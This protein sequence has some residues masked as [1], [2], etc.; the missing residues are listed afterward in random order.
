MT[1]MAASDLLR[2]IG[3]VANKK[4]VQ[5]DTSPLI[6]QDLTVTDAFTFAA[7]VSNSIDLV[8]SNCKFIGPVLFPN[9]SNLQR[10]AFE[11]CLFE[12]TIELRDFRQQIV[13][14]GSVFNKEVRIHSA[15]MKDFGI[16]NILINDKLALSGS[17]FGIL[18]LSNINSG[19]DRSGIK[20]G[21]SSTRIK[22]LRTE[23]IVV[24]RFEVKETQLISDAVF[25]NV[26]ADF[27]DFNIVQIGHILEILNCDLKE[28]RLDNLTANHERHVKIRD[29]KIQEYHV[30]LNMYNRLEVTNTTFRRLTLSGI[31]SGYHKIEKTDAQTLRLINVINEGT[32]ILSQ[33]EVPNGGSLE[34]KSSTLGKTDFLLCKFSEAR[35]EFENSKVS[36]IFCSETDFPKLVTVNKK[37]NFAQAQLAFGQLNTAFSKQGDTV[38][39]LEYQSREIE[40]HYNNINWSRK[41]F[42]TKL[43]LGL[44]MLSSN[45]G[46]WWGRAVL[47][48]FTVGALFFYLVVLW[49]E[50]YSFALPIDFDSRLIPS[51]L[52]FMNPLRVFDTEALFRV[53]EPSS[54]LTLTELSYVFDF[55]GR[56]FVAY[57]F[58]QTIQAFRRFGRK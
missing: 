41:N 48:T 8:F 51:Y 58:Y 24:N 16:A 22:H 27:L 19:N 4:E 29:C 55:I 31:N 2:E 9:S 14:D 33:T 32:L 20:I 39:S 28:I 26:R 1:E 47:F 57:G 50:E 30:L 13:L 25:E 54:F 23:A 6:C 10:L 52:K 37:K 17:F 45:F 15:E 34:M 5:R 40:A 43:N 35:L 12:S 38:R 36:E 53:N 21:G 49:S 44:N 7:N 46:R 11:K 3:M 18:S 56:V 42:F